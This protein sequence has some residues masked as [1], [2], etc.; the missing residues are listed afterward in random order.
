MWRV[1][2]WRGEK[3]GGRKGGREVTELTGRIQGQKGIE[4]WC[5]FPS[6]FFSTLFLPKK[7]AAAA[8]CVVHTNQVR[9]FRS[10]GGGG[11]STRDPWLAA[12]RV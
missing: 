1:T 3:E 12:P 11:G 2:D 6:L 8:A 10:R 9:T 4:P 5:R 7:P